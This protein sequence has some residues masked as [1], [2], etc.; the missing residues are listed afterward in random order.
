MKLVFFDDYKLG[1]VRG[2]RVIDAAPVLMGINA[3]TPQDLINAVIAEWDSRFREAFQWVQTTD[4]QGVPLSGVKLRAPLPH[5]GKIV[6]MAANYMEDGALKEPRPI[7]AFLKSSDSVIATGETVVLTPYEATIFHHEAEIALVFGRTGRNVTRQEAFKYIFGYVNFNDV[8][9]RGLHQNSFYFQKSFDTFGP[10]GPYL[11]TAD[12]VGDPYAMQMRLWVDGQARHDY[13]ISD[14]G[15]K[16]D[17]CVEYVT[18]TTIMEPGDII[19]LGTNHQGIGPVQDGNKVEQEC[20]PL[21]RLVFNVT[22]ASKRKWPHEIDKRMA[23][24]VAGRTA[25]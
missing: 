11:V 25:R 7:N 6:C 23:D 12:E 2:D 21:G 3:P 9:A 17:R 5:P 14:M 13:P 20:G 16:I 24:A 1:I 18:A 22:D 4:N 19:S 10:M 8:S 15:H